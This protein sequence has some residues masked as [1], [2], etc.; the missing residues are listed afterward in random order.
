MTF[1]GYHWP[2]QMRPYIYQLAHVE[3]AA[4]GDAA[5]S[6]AVLERIAGGDR[7]S[8]QY[9]CDY[10]DYDGGLGDQVVEHFWGLERTNRVR[11]GRMVSQRRA[12]AMEVPDKFEADATGVY[13]RFKWWPVMDSFMR[14]ELR[15]R[16]RRT[17]RQVPHRVG[18]IAM[19]ALS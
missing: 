11:S 14:A 1:Y 5:Q 6:V 19:V 18:R 10:L 17:W 12:V 2:N 3:N 8:R 7:V 9:L 16:R 15:N 13:I 4:N